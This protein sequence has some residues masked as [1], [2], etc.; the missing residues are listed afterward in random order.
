MNLS[1]WIEEYQHLRLREV[2]DRTLALDGWTLGLLAEGLGD[3]DLDAITRLGAERWRAWLLESGVSLTT[4]SG[5]CRRARACMARAYRLELCKSNPLACLSTSAPTP[6][7]AAVR[8]TQEQVTALIG[9]APVER[10]WRNLMGLCALAGLRKGEALRLTWE[11]VGRDRLQIPRVK[12]APREVRLESELAAL[13][14]E[15]GEPD[16]L[17]APV[18]EG[19]LWRKVQG[20]FSAADLGRVERPLRT[21][22]RWRAQTWAMTYP[23][24]VVDAW[25]GHSLAVARK[26]YRR[27]PDD[28]YVRA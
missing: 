11:A 23:E 28:Y 3:P 8:L 6:D 21:L 19:D 7:Y 14:T 2:A 5:H 16:R 25:M 13:L 18:P 24:A 20:F 26:H 27:V 10:G 1:E 17:I 4:V 15:R 22:R 12:T 9:A